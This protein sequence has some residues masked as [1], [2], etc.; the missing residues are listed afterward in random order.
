MPPFKEIPKT[1]AARS[2]RPDQHGAL[3]QREEIAQSARQENA[4][5]WAPC[6]RKGPGPGCG[7][8]AQEAAAVK[9]KAKKPKATRARYSKG[10]GL[11][12]M[13][14]AIA[15]WK[16]EQLK[17]PEARMSMHLFAEVHDIPFTNL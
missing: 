11:M 5:I 1:E 2:A 16:V 3:L 13:T 9:P 15:A 10:K 17:T 4:E 12:K 7:P 14:N 8:T 6:R